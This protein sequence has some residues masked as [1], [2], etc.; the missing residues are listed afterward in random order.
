[1]QT[2]MMAIMVSYL[3]TSVDNVVNISNIAA[4]YVKIVS[5]FIGKS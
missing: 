1:M 3:D 5:N 2:F 4:K